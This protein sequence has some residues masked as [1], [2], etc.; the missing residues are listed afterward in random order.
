MC[1]LS[2]LAISLATAAALFSAPVTA[3][4]YPA[5]AK[6]ENKSCGYCHV[7]AAGGG[8]RNYRGAYYKGH[9]LSFAS[10]DDTAEAKKAGVEVG[11]DPTPNPT[12][13]T[14]PAKAG[15]DKAK[16]GKA[17][18]GKAKKPAKNTKK[19]KKVSK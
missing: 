8:A 7:R 4:A 18:A 1:R 16:T 14:P 3:H 6:K 12:S 15:A 11:P 2:A 17:K 19:P 9:G 13:Y 10:F 5:Y